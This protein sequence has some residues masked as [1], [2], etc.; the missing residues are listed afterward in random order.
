MFAGF[1]AENIG[2]LLRRQGVGEQVLGLA[3]V[4]EQVGAGGEV[5]REF[6]DQP[7]E[8]CRGD[9]AEPGGGAR[10]RLANPVRRIA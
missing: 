10:D 1:S 6:V 3:R 4:A 8:S 2:D 7:I 5:G 9:R